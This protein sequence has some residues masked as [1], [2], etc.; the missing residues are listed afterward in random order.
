MDEAEPDSVGKQ[1][2]AEAIVALKEISSRCSRLSSL[3]GITTLLHL[4]LVLVLAFTVSGPQFFYVDHNVFR[5]WIAF[6]AGL[7]ACALFA[8][9]VLVWRF[10]LVARR[11][12]LVY[13][14]ISDEVEKGEQ[15]VSRSLNIRLSLRQFVL[16]ATL[17]L[18]LTGGSGAAIFIGS[19]VAL[20]LWVW[21][22]ISLQARGM[23]F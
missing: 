16:D 2:L 20:T 19:N 17:P 6:L 4:V 21:L 11:G 12:N 18:S 5:L 1:Q 10:D 14:E 3:V 7:D 15:F 23:G 13:Q 22:N 8:T 9:I